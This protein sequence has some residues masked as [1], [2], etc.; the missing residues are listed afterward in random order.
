MRLS[1]KVQRLGRNLRQGLQINIAIRDL[2]D[3]WQQR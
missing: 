1:R 2:E 3:L